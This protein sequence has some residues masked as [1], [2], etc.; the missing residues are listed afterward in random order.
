MTSRIFNI[1]LLAVVLTVFTT[2]SLSRAQDVPVGALIGQSL[3]KLQQDASPEAFQNCV[4]ELKRIDAMAPGSAAPK[5]YIA[6][7]SLNFAVTNPHAEQTESLIAEAEQAISQL[8]E[9]KEADQSDL[10]TLKGFLYMVRIVQDP[11]R[12]GQRYYLDV[13]DYYEKALKLNPDNALAR[14]LQEKFFEGM[15]AQ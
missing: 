6:L 12:N 7:Q 4:A 3:A 11:A 8:E 14:Q 15:R 5:Y 2:L 10:C 9:I 13:M 1:R